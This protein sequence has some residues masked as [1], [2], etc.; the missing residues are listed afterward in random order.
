[1]SAPNRSF[2]LPAPAVAL[3]G[4]FVPGAGYWLIG[5]RARGVVVLCSIVAL[6]GLGLLIAGVRVIEVPGYDNQSGQSI[7]INSSGHRLSPT[8][9]GYQNASWVLLGGGFISEVANK[10]WFVAQIMAGPLCL[11]NAKVSIDLARA[12]Y[13]RGAEVTYPR[14]HAPLETVGTLYTAIAGMLNLYIIIDSAHRAANRPED[15]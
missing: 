10:P 9:S 1:M 8:D 11:A 5:E 13:S 14:P 4:W 12:G 2:N 6:Y 7:R 3:A 15:E